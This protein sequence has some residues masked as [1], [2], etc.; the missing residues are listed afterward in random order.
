MNPNNDEI[1]NA[2]QASG[3]L[4]EQ[5]IATIFEKNDYFVKTNVAFKDI[6]EEKSREIDVMAY[7][8]IHYDDE[9]KISVGIRVLAECK[10][11]T[12]PFVFICRDKNSYDNN[13]TPPN[14]VFPQVE[15]RI[16][17]EGKANYFS[18]VKAFNYYN[19]NIHF[20]FHKKNTKAVQFCKIVR[21]GKDW[22]A[23]HEGI[24][25]GLIIPIVK[26]LEHWK[27][28]DSHKTEWKSYTIYFPLIVLNSEIYSIDS[29]QSPIKIDKV[30][31]VSFIR[32][33][34]SKTLK[35]TYLVDFVNKQGLEIFIKD[36]ITNFVGEFIKAIK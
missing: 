12:N 28:H 26:S 34:H 7:K 23:M 2:V 18:V 10:N 1:L 30:S 31:N 19:L 6:D 25:D 36:H 3:Y 22:L 11:N 4:F 8:R 13:Y 17:I 33:I 21:K 5:E 24:Y 27:T 16:P 15:Y 29:K 35:D 14:F 20:P 32:E 9:N